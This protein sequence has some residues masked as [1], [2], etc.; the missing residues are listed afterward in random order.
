MKDLNVE[1]VQ[2][3][4]LTNDELL[5]TTGGF[6]PLIIIGGALLLTGC[7]G[8]KVTITGKYREVEGSI[9]IDRTKQ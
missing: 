4:D 7:A 1:K 8:S 6:V 3:I 5:N 9:T 2:L